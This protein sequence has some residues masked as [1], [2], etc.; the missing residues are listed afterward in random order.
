VKAANTPTAPKSVRIDQCKA[1]SEVTSNVVM[2]GSTTYTALKYTIRLT[3]KHY[4]S[5]TI[6][7]VENSVTEVQCCKCKLHDTVN[8]EQAQLDHF[9]KSVE[10][11]L[12]NIKLN[13]GGMILEAGIS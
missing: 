9:Y 7:V 4:L 1:L 11:L 2:L 13:S 10:S 5:L 12:K 8:K 6:T 3:I